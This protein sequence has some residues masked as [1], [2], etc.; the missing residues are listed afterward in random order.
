MYL[1]FFKITYERIANTE[2]II[3]KEEV[4]IHRFPEIESTP[5]ETSRVFRRWE[6]REE[7]PVQSLYWDSHRKKWVRQHRHIKYVWDCVV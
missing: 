6:K 4:Y 5:V 2:M 3:M 7:S 1:G